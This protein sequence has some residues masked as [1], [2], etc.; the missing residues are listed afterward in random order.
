MSDLPIL[1]YGSE[2][3]GLCQADPIKRFHLSFLKSILCVKSSTP[4]CFV[5][6]E[7]G[8]YPLLIGRQISV[9]KYWIKIIQQPNAFYV[10]QVYNELLETNINE[11]TAVT[12]VSLVKSLLYKCGMG[13]YWVTQSVPNV[14]YFL[15]I[16][17]QRL[18][19]MFL[20]EWNAEVALTSTSRLY[21]HIKD[22]FGFESYLNLCKK[23]HRIA[24]TK[25]RLSSHLFYIE[26]GRWGVRKVERGERKCIA[27]SVI[28]DEYHCLLECP[29]YVNERKYCVPEK[30]RKR[31][32]MFEFVN[33][34]KSENEQTQRML[35]VLCFRVQL[36]HKTFL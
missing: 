10:R 26:R 18:H 22:N 9:I 3:W 28:E 7:L 31:P 34:L 20:Q 36:K 4:N 21:K 19:D 2:I 15:A 24:I 16:F 6:G 35:G 1:S 33:F 5:Y 11:P 23:S 30:L 29:R 14:S 27:C 12:W 8:V 25:I 32:S 17:K 13:N